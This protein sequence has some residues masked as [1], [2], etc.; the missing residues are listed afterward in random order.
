M[1]LLKTRLLVVL[2]AVILVGGLAASYVNV[3]A[4]PINNNQ[5]SAKRQY[6][7][8]SKLAGGV[9]IRFSQDP[10]PKEI[11]PFLDEEQSEILQARE[12]T[13]RDE[14]I[15]ERGMAFRHVIDSSRGEVL[16]FD[17]PAN[18]VE[19]TLEELEQDPRIDKV[20]PVTIGRVGPHPTSEPP[21]VYQVQQAVRPQEVSTGTDGKITTAFLD[22]GLRQSDFTDNLWTAPKNSASDLDV[23]GFTILD[24][25]TTNTPE[26]DT[27]RHGSATSGILR[28]NFIAGA[29]ILG[30]DYK[31]QVFMIRMI[32]PNG[33][34][35]SDDLLAGIR[36]IL[37]Y[38]NIDQ[39]IR[40]I[41]MSL[42]SFGYDPFMEELLA[43]FVSMG[44]QVVTSA[45]NGS[46]GVGRDLTSNPGYPGGYGIRIPLGVISGTN[47]M[48]RPAVW[49]D[50]YA[51]MTTTWA[52]GEGVDSGL[53]LWLSGTSA[54]A[55][56]VAATAAL[57]LLMGD[58]PG[59][60][61]QSVIF[62]AKPDN[63]LLGKVKPGGGIFDP[64]NLLIGA[65]SPLLRP[66]TQLTFDK[67]KTGKVVGSSTD[68]NTIYV[69]G[70]FD[71]EITPKPDL[72][73]KKGSLGLT[74]TPS[75]F[76]VPDGYAVREQR[77]KGL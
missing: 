71:V 54:S 74:K 51:N 56:Y 18:Q 31:I 73:F 14:F 33:S 26:E 44:G 76:C 3:N 13:R 37:D 60:A 23:H 59:L 40:L 63:D 16:K 45:G 29:Q 12:R 75:Y 49:S 5:R 58:S 67:A 41:N 50:Y 10:D 7:D 42:G 66:P 19:A 47:L 15:A 25:V 62:S 36:K 38:A 2:A 24:G 6:L 70:R 34:G 61:L 55:P 52:P 30:K 65:G 8:P 17:V 9:L 21:E 11:G 39:T 35:N 64:N 77:I 22:S 43:E 69:A 46:Q 57:R 27:L 20:T 1:R 53:L 68:R 48:G 28:K 72:S 4:K 32:H